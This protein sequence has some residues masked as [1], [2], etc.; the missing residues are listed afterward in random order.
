MWG[1]KHYK[2]RTNGSITNHYP[3]QSRLSRLLKRLR[4]KE[5]STPLSTIETGNTPISTGFRSSWL[6]VIK[7]DGCIISTLQ[8]NKQYHRNGNFLPNSPKTLLRLGDLD[9]LAATSES[10]TKCGEQAGKEWYQINC[11]NPRA[12]VVPPQKVSRPSEP[13]PN[14]F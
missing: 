1:L 8:P 5:S 4:K 13:T 12:P 9:R 2:K 6:L 14:T 11:S 10:G 7:P 3:T